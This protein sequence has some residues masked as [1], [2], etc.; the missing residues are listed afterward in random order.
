[1]TD[2]TQNPKFYKSKCDQR[3]LVSQD[4]G[5]V[6]IEI[7][8]RGKQVRFQ[9]RGQSMVPLIQDGDVLTIAPSSQAPPGIGKVVAFKQAEARSLIVH[10]VIGRHE[11][12]YLIKG[13]NSSERSDCWIPEREIIGCVIAVERDKKRINFGLGIERYLIAFLSRVSLLSKISG[14]VARLVKK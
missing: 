3:A 14:R 9:A 2:R 10:R 11:G 13:D 7:L 8:A 4:F 5:I 12:N 1:M 6:L